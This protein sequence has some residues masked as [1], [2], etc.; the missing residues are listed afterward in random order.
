[1]TTQKNKIST[2][3]NYILNLEEQIKFLKQ[4]ISAQNDTIKILATARESQ[5]TIVPQVPQVPEP[6]LLEHND[7]DHIHSIT[8]QDTKDSLT[9]P[10]S[11]F[12]RRLVV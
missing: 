9:N 3:E 11:F 12:R 8:V 1:M 6:A 2:L 10:T 4:V 7:H 5:S